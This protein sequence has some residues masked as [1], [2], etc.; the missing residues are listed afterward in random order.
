MH[1]NEQLGNNARLIQQ[2]DGWGHC[3]LNQV[4]YCTAQATQDFMLNGKIPDQNH[5]LCGVDEVPFMPFEDTAD[6]RGDDKDEL[7]MAWRVLSEQW[8]LA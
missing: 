2:L 1:A 7:R 5:T 4:S 8:L 3:A 6:P